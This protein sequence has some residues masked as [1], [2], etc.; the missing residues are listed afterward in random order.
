MRI[1][2]QQSVNFI[3][4]TMPHLQYISFH[5]LSKCDIPPPPSQGKTSQ[6]E[7]GVFFPSNCQNYLAI[8]LAISLHAQSNRFPMYNSSI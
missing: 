6:V 5:S 2:P 8:T 4:N 1:T 3:L 7:C